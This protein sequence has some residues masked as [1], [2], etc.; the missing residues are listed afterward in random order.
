MNQLAWHQR[1]RTRLIGSIIL[2]LLFLTVIIAALIYRGFQSTQEAVQEQSFQGLL[3]QGQQRLLDLT[4]LEARNNDLLLQQVDSVTRQAATALSQTYLNATDLRLE[5]PLAALSIT[6]TG[7]RYDADPER[8]SDVILY[9]NIALSPAIERNYQ[10]SRLL[11]PVFTGQLDDIP[12]VVALFYTDPAGL[13]RYVPPID[14]HELVLPTFPVT[15]QIFFTIAAPAANPQRI[16]QWTP[17]YVDP[18]GNG[19]LITVST[20]VYEDNTFRGVIGADVSLEQLFSTINNFKPTPGSFITILDNQNKLIAASDQALDTFFQTPGGATPTFT[21]TL[22]LPLIA[23]GNRQLEN[24]LQATRNNQ[25][26]FEQVTLH[27]QDYVLFYA[28]LTTVDWTLVLAV[29]QAEITLEAAGIIQT[30]ETGTQRTLWSTLLTIGTMMLAV[31]LLAFLFSQR[32]IRP[33]DELAQG[34]QAIAAGDFSVR[35]HTPANNELGVL[36]ASFNQMVDR[37]NH[38]QAELQQVNQNLEQTITDRTRELEAEQQSLQQ[39]LQELQSM[40]TTVARLTTPIIPVL[41][42]VVV[43][44]IVGTLDPQ[45]VE[46]LEVSMLHEVARQ[47]AH[48]VIID[49][50]GLDQ[51]DANT[52]ERFAESLETLYLLGARP[53]LVGV[54][55]DVAQHLILS[56]IDLQNL[57]TMSDLQAAINSVVRRQ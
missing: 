49:V 18:A 5:E 16:T 15:R 46:S 17:P 32:L 22:G 13:T 24:V 6:D 25:T 42:G 56:S 44:P 34:T 4:Q 23:G 40:T 1:I 53:I 50:T 2:L 3:R 57:Q 29:P 45:R 47:R 7:I 28:P 27:D 41:Q 21:E 55:P 10:Y 39:A 12:S 54:H 30:I 20:P 52:A 43:V 19:L 26:G 31:L 36:A 51:L 35:L 37:L 11:D 48:T 38:S 33:I 14:L 9:E 8:L